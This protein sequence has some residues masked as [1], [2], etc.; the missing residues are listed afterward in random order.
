MN[1]LVKKF[2]VIFE[3]YAVGNLLNYSKVKYFLKFTPPPISKYIIILIF[4]FTEIGN[5]KMLKTYISLSSKVIIS[6]DCK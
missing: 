6:F 3:I 1:N 2:I 5:N 4:N